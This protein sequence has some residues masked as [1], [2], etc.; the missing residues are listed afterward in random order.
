MRQVGERVFAVGGN[1][2]YISMQNDELVRQL[3]ISN[4]WNRLRIGVLFAIEASQTIYDADFVIGACNY[5]QNGDGIYSWSCPNWCGVGFTDY[6]GS[7]NLAYTGGA[8]PYFTGYQYSTY[9]VGNTRAWWGGN[10][11]PTYMP[12]SVGTPQRRG[13]WIIQVT[14]GSPNFSVDAWG[15]NSASLVAQD[16]T[17]ENLIEA[18]A[19]NNNPPFVGTTALVRW[20]APTASGAISESN[21]IMDSVSV[22][23]KNMTYALEI[24][25]VA[26]YRVY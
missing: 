3:G 25:G 8:A 18:T 26:V 17:Y 24:Y 4:D 7:T 5:G 1:Q 2:K 16:W 14:K 9:R 12:A 21:G 22:A 13:I 20:A 15:V 11:S 19:Q 23:W 10:V 6:D